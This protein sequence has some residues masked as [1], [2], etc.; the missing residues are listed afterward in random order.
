M[1]ALAANLKATTGSASIGETLNFLRIHA[2]QRASGAIY[3]L[4][5]PDLIVLDPPRT[6]LGAENL[7]I[8]G[9]DRRARAGLRLLR[10]GHAGPRSARAHSLPAT[11]SSPSPSPTSFRRPSIWKQWS[12]CA[13]PDR[14]EG[15]KSFSTFRRNAT[16]LSYVSSASPLRPPPRARRPRKPRLRFFCAVAL[17]AAGIAAAHGFYSLFA[18]QPD[19]DRAGAAGR[20]LRLGGSACA[21]DCMAAAGR[22]CGCCWA[23]GA[24]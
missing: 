21:T 10:S 5:L 8:A 14:L 15:Q 6:G 11:E 18:A 20:A 17:F 4:G 7:R 1:Q 23:H 13:A 9:R 22:A 16:I 24:R 19:A 12:S 2:Q 3:S